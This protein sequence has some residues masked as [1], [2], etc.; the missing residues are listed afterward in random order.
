MSDEVAHHLTGISESMRGFLA[1]VMDPEM[2]RHAADPAA[3]N[4]IAGNPQELALPEY[5][6][7]LQRWAEPKDKDWFGYKM[8]HRPALAAAAEGL[9]KELGLSFGAEDIVLTRGAQ[10]WPRH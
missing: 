4:F 1:A 10:P 7:S 8:P 6:R 2:G 5:V 9:S 3:S